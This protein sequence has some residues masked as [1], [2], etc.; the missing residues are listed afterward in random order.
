MSQFYR[1]LIIVSLLLFLASP[2]HAAKFDDIFVSSEWLKQNIDN[3]GMVVID[4]RGEKAY[5]S[6]HIPGSFPISWQQLSDMT[7]EFATS[8]WGTVTD[9][10]SLSTVISSLGITKDSLVVIYAD[11]VKGWGEDGRI[12]WTFNMAGL[13]NLKILDGGFKAWKKSG[14]EVSKGSEVAIKSNFATNSLDRADSID[15]ETLLASYKDFKI[16][17]TR[18][19]DEFGGAT[20]FGEKRGG[21]LPGSINLAYAD[22]LEDGFVKSSD[23]IEVLMK[24]NGIT[25]DDKLVAYCTAGIRSAWV[26]VALEASGYNIQNYDESF[27]V[28]ATNEQAPMGKVVKKKAYNFVTADQLKSKIDNKEDVFI[29]D[30]QP[31]DDFVKHHIPGAVE[32]AAYPVK[33]DEEKNKI[34]EALAKAKK[35]TENITVICPRGEGGARRTVDHLVSTGI[36]ASNIYILEEGQKGWKY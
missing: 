31:H 28:W 4:A 26:Q 34:D 20:K 12:F 5:K 8:G 29:L 14:A 21:H 36:D 33:K 15:T 30:I 7:P 32:T 17:D 19:S 18:A 25:K 22:F 10:L 6:G 27:Y 3:G 13:K 1:S 2:I 24:E 23:Q 11:T 16:I 35:G 9:P